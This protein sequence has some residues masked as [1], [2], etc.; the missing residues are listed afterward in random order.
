M[1]IRD[2]LQ[3]VVRE[4]LVEGHRQRPHY[5]LSAAD[6]VEDVLQPF[7]LR[8]VLRKN[9][10]VV[11]PQGVADHVVGEH[12]EILVELRL[13][14]RRK[15]HRR[16][17]GPLRQV[18]AQQQEPRPR[19]IGQQ[20]VAAGQQ[21]IRLLGTL[22]VYKRQVFKERMNAK[23]ARAMMI[24]STMPNLVRKVFKLAI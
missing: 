9:I 1:C 7:D 23:R 8:L 13:R 21:R 22:D 20:A 15:A 5:G 24:E 16:R 3:V 17:G 19:Q 14:R 12:L 11:S 4:P 10:G 2:R 6:L 18:V